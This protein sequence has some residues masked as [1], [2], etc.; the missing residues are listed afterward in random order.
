MNEKKISSRNIAQLVLTAL[1]AA[2][3]CVVGPLSIPIGPIPL[4]LTTLVLYVLLYV[5]GF[6]YTLAACTLYLL[7]GLAGLP[8]FTGFQGG[9]A[10]LAGPTGGYLIGYLPM[11][12]IG[13]LAI[14]ARAGRVWQAL[15]LLAAT[16]VLYGLGTAWFMI[17][18]GTP[19][20]GAMMLCVV[21]FL[22]GDVV[23]IAIA[24]GVGPGF[25]KRIGGE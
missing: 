3:L 5:V 4:S 9:V 18:T 15:G 6:R 14:R 19:L 2:V 20:G 10:K 17:S 24:I 7:I 11:I 8:V 22:P 12:L 25:R 23:K 1:A 16:A 21:P 13:G